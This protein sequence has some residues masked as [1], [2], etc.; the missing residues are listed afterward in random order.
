MREVFFVVLC[1][2]ASVAA[3]TVDGKWVAKVE[4]RQGAQ[5]IVFDLKTEGDRVTGSVA[6]GR[7]QRTLPIQEGKIQGDEVTFTTTGKGRKQ[8]VKMVWTARVTAN[9]L[10][11]SAKRE[12]RR[13]GRPFTAMRQQ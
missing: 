13:R 6:R 2:V 12:G 4:A 11:G 7:K 3:A 5:E 1:G 8:E 10:K 9:E